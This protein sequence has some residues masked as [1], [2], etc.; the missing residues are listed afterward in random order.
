MIEAIEA[1]AEK[2]LGGRT[3]SLMKVFVRDFDEFG[4]REPALTEE[5]VKAKEIKE[6]AI[7]AVSDESHK[8]AF[9]LGFKYGSGCEGLLKQSCKTSFQWYKIAAERGMPLAQ[10]ITARA[11]IK[12][13]CV[14][15][16]IDEAVR[17]LRMA[18]SEENEILFS[19]ANALFTLGLVLFANNLEDKDSRQE[20]LAYMTK[21]A[22]L[23]DTGAMKFL[24]RTYRGRIFDEKDFIDSDK[25][26]Y[27]EKE[28]LKLIKY[29]TGV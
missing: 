16:N 21:A 17:L 12:G 5:A 8:N 13:R 9:S 7:N 20:G 1:L 3:G 18:A 25:A 22:E 15:K 26:E 28:L 2:Q 24:W 27:W 6:A 19:R 4:F 23:G 14:E 11:Y 29:R 10:I